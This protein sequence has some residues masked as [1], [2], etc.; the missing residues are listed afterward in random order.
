MGAFFTVVML[1]LAAWAP[2][3]RQTV[4]IELFQY[5]PAVVRAAAGDTIV[6]ENKDIVPHTA[7][8]NDKSWDSGNIAAAARVRTIAK[9]KGEHEFI[10]VYH[11]NM[12]GKLIV[13]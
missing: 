6:W 2:A 10:C 3:K 8:A 7:T 13:K 12:K 1:A 11:P 5:K 9:K 4:T